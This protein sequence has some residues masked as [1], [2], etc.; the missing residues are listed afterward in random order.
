M[1]EEYPKSFSHVENNFE[2]INKAV[3]YEVD[4]YKEIA[5][6]YKSRKW[7]NIAIC[8]AIFALAIS[9]TGLAY[10]FFRTPVDYRF[11]NTL[12]DTSQIVES[13]QEISDQVLS[14]QE[15]PSISTSFTVFTRVAS[16]TGEVVVT[17]KTFNPADLSSP[18]EQYCYLEKL[19]NFGDVSAINLAYARSEKIEY[20]TQDSD[21]IKIAELNCSFFGI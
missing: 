21:L 10:W 4:R 14:A 20:D 18:E 13:L 3:D 8:S 17:G 19:T 7:I 12:T 2:Y 1:T 16:D 6:Y 11:T 5:E 15:Q 9:L